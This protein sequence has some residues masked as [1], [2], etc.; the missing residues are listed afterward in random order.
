M[1]SKKKLEQPTEDV[2]VEK[3]EVIDEPKEEKE[4]Q[5][6]QPTEDVSKLEK[7]KTLLAKQTVKEVVKQKEIYSVMSK[8]T[9]V[10][11]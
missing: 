7:M 2:V 1:A 4:V 10:R 3:N 11:N 9:V 6:E 5:L 8:M